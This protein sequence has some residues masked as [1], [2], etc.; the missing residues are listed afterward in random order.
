MNKDIRNIVFYKFESEDESLWQT[1]FFYTDGSILNTDY[2]TGKEYT[3][4]FLKEKGIDDLRKIIDKKYVYRATGNEFIKM[5]QRFRGSDDPYKLNFKIEKEKTNIFNGIITG[6][7]DTKLFSKIKSRVERIKNNNKEIKEKNIK[8]SNK[9]NPIKKFFNKTW[10]KIAAFATA[11][12]LIVLPAASCANDKEEQSE[13]TSTQIEESL[14]LTFD[15]IINASTSTRQKT[16]MSGVSDCLDEYNIGFA[17]AYY[18]EEKDI[19]AA[20]SW[21]EVMAM[22]IVY[23]NYS[24]NDYIEIFNGAELDQVKL[25]D[26]F[27]T[28]NLQLFGAYILE[29]SEYPVQ[30]EDILITDEAKAFYQK[31]HKMFLECK[32]STGVDQIN[33]VNAFYKQLYKDFPIDFETREEGI[34]HSDP[35]D[36]ISTYKFSIIPM[37]SAAEVLFQNLEIDYTLAD[38]AID[39]LDDIGICNRANDIIEKA[40]LVNLTAQPSSSYAEYEQLKSAKIEELAL[41]SSYVVDDEHRDI[42]QLTDFK[43]QVNI[44]FD[45]T[46]SNFNGTIIYSDNSSYIYTDDKD[47]AISLVGI[48]RVE[49]AENIY[50]ASIN[51]E[52]NKAKHDALIKSEQEANRKQ[53]EENNKKKEYEDKI[54]S[55]EQ[56]LNNKI[57]DAN[58]NQSSGSNVNESDFGNH[59]VDFDDE[60]SDEF[61]NLDD[62]VKDIT[63]D[64]TGDKTDEPLPD[65]NSDYNNSY[66]SKDNESSQNIYEYEIPYTMTKEEIVDAIVDKMATQEENTDAKVY[67][68][69]V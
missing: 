50:D 51:N 11:V 68:Y 52:N 20:F 46:N 7:T 54:K 35:R 60:Y 28:A 14:P 5:F 26:A 34:A 30:I 38:K 17:S 33:K 18:E 24:K 45:Y 10:K 67:T 31:Y 44:A 21:D 43:E 16:I 65:P 29:T 41:Q 61:G 6:I 13:K 32:E 57:N 69:H 58:Q 3:I 15:D 22:A 40:A 47:K 25:Q 36:N 37:V 56:D 59:N 12:A 66:I 55:E 2:E 1:C 23:N 49:T 9:E 42:S 39:Y 4:E 64:P 19:S 27:K 53:E 62:S 63:T 48:D 8:K